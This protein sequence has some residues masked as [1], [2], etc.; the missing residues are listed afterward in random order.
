MFV[1]MILACS[2]K[3]EELQEP[4]VQHYEASSLIT[5]E[6]S[7][8]EFEEGYWVRRTMNPSENSIFEEFVSSI[9]GT[10]ITY[11][12]RVDI[13]AKTFEI[14]FSDEKYSGNGT[15]VGEGLDWSSWSSTSTHRDGN[16]VQSEDSMEAQGIIQSSKVGY[17]SADSV[18]WRLEEELLPITQ[19]EYEQALS[20]FEE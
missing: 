11:T 15:F 1:L 6:D 7:G 9:D 5:L 3:G 4:S 18:D 13:E 12:Y 14:D 17:S 16:Y 10:L 20:L 19:E 8:M 2:D